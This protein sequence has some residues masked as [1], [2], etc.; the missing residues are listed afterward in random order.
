MSLEELKKKR[1]QYLKKLYDVT[2]GDRYSHV[3][4]Y[5]L[6]KDLGF[7]RKETEGIVD[8]LFGEHLLT[9]AGL[10]G[11]ISMTHEGVKEVESALDNPKKPTEHFP[12]INIIQVDKMINSQIQQST[13]ES[14]QSQNVINQ[15]H[16]GTLSEDKKRGYIAGVISIII[17][18]IFVVMV[19]NFGWDLTGQILT[20]FSALF[21]ILGIGSLIKP[22]SVGQVTAQILQN[23]HQNI[24]KEEQHKYHSKRRN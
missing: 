24:A 17:C 3:S 2:E 12:P 11:I 9:Y 18:I 5:D 7:E 20:A 1:L 14:E 13:K 23:I 16:V 19:L 15:I 8:Y 10:G 22:E 21:G 4:M 6:G